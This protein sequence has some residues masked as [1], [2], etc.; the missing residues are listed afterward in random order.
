MMYGYIVIYCLALLIFNILA[1][2]AI[3]I[4]CCKW[5]TLGCQFDKWYILVLKASL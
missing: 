4:S 1:F 3:H 2:Y 5:A